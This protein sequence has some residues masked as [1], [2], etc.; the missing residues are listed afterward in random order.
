MSVNKIYRRNGNGP[1]DTRDE[2]CNSCK[3][4]RAVMRHMSRLTQLEIFIVNEF[5]VLSST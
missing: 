4:A 1:F 5:C 3:N 2:K